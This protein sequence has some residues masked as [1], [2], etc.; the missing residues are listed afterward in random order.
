MCHESYLLQHF[1]YLLAKKSIE[2]VLPPPSQI[3]CVLF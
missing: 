1:F 2:T 3:V